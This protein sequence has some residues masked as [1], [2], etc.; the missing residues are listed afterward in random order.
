[1]YEA[2]FGCDPDHISGSGFG[3]CNEQWKWNSGSL[4]A[5]KDAYHTTDR[6]MSAVEQELVQKAVF[7]W[8]TLGR[9]TTQLSDPLAVIRAYV[10]F[11]YLSLFFDEFFFGYART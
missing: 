8:I 10:L 9:S 6:T 2:V 1:M 4:N 5:N 11:Y 3:Y 7:N